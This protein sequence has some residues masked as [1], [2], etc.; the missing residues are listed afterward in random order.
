MNRPTDIITWRMTRDQ[1]GHLE[2]IQHAFTR[3]KEMIA[4]DDYSNVD[5]V[6]GFISG[7]LSNLLNEIGKLNPDEHA[8]VRA[9]FEVFLSSGYSK[10]M[11]LTLEEHEGMRQRGTLQDDNDPWWKELEADLRRADLEKELVKKEDC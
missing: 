5:I 2:R 4:N 8:K 1:Y 3:V 10:H 7:D 9:Q 6:M 11:E